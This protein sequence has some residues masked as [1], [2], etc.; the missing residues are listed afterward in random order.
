MKRIKQLIFL[1]VTVICF[2]ACEH[3][4]VELQSIP[5]NTPEG[6]SIYATG[7]FNN[8]N[9]ADP[10]YKLQLDPVT[11]T[12]FTEIP[13]GFGKISYKFTRGDWSSVETDSCGGDTDNRMLL[14]DAVDLPNDWVSGWK[15][16]SPIYCNKLTIVLDSIPRNTPINSAIYLSG[17]IN[18]WMLGQAAFKF[19]KG[20]DNKYYLT[21]PRREDRLIFKLNR[22]SWESI[23]VDKNNRDI[24]SREIVFG[25]KDT[26]HISMRNWIDLPYQESITKT[27]VITKLPNLNGF[28]KIYLSGSFNNWHPKDENY[29][30]KKD[31]NGLYYINFTFSSKDV[32]YYKVTLGGWENRELKANGAEMNNRI[33]LKTDPDTQFIKIENCAVKRELPKSFN[34]IE[35]AVNKT[36]ETFALPT[37]PIK[38]DYTGKTPVRKILFMIDK[39]PEMRQKEEGVFL[40]GDFNN[41]QTDL[42]AFEFK[43][44]KNGKRYYF[45]KLYDNKDHYYK[46]TR[47][48]WGKE[49]A[50]IYRNKMGNKHIPAGTKDD[51]IHLSIKNWVD[52]LPAR[53]LTLIITALPQST[54]VNTAIY[55]TGDFNG[56]LPNMEQFRFKNSNGQWLLTIPYFSEE[57]NEFKITRGDWN[58]EF[59]SARGRVL[60]NQSFRRSLNRD[61][62]F[63]K[64]EGWKDLSR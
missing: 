30:F 52:Y 26:V 51:T 44:L 23:E 49:E 34:A 48:D 41:W 10:D 47:G 3:K 59:S 64:V 28:Q 57:F 11:Q 2:T 27:L 32:A 46:I 29:T 54:P 36:I 45:L 60:P 19:T 24:E 9:P 14:S 38:P 62:L 8:W 43:E 7:N 58:N 21:V 50:D 63:L 56:W 13:L 35:T 22:G 61:T 25:D 17:N 53:K 1:L 37:V 5:S 55:L 16:L 15:D 4:R 33:L 40:A 42:P 18:Y 20:E 31:A 12:W 6:A 39:M